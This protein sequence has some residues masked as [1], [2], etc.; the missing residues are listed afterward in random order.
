MLVNKAVMTEQ[1]APPQI[2]AKLN[3]GLRKALRPLFI[4][5]FQLFTI[6]RCG[7]IFGPI[8]SELEKNKRFLHPQT[9]YL[10]YFNWMFMEF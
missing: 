8:L 3:R 4:R 6:L 1:D 9:K 7:L 2:P 10:L 5:G